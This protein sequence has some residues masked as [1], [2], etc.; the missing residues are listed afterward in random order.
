M[1]KLTILTKLFLIVI[2]FLGIFTPNE[3]SASSEDV[4]LE[5]LDMED[6]QSNP[7]PN[8]AWGDD[9][10]VTVLDNGLVVAIREQNGV[11][12]YQI[13]ERDDYNYVNWTYPTDI[14]SG[15]K[16]TVTALDNGDVL[17]VYEHS[18]RFS[19][20]KLYY[21]LGRME[22][23]KV[24]WYTTGNEFVEDGS[25]VIGYDPS[26]TVLDNGDVLIGYLQMFNLDL[27]AVYLVGRHDEEK[28]EMTWID[29][30]RFDEVI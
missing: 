2:L 22:D 4:E 14:G 16:P 29:Q 10:S 6:I 5:L 19:L 20:T 28:G 17:L 12:S 1:K 8:Y 30:H 3:A 11:L 23:G 24:D 26:V 27:E 21:S 13:G 7:D 18:E 25:S 9:P 15:K